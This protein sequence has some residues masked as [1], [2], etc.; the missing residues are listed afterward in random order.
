M[1]V[2]QQM[3]GKH[4]RNEYAY[5]KGANSVTDR[6]RILLLLCSVTSQAGSLV[7]EISSQFPRQCVFVCLF[8]SCHQSLD[9]SC[10][11]FACLP[12]NADSLILFVGFNQVLSETEMWRGGSWAVFTFLLLLFDDSM[13]HLSCP[14]VSYSHALF[15][16]LRGQGVLECFV[17]STCKTRLCD[18][19]TYV[20]LRR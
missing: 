14:A 11:L 12:L 7:M 6:Y 9:R 3:A 15:C 19:A 17:A 2:R 20:F 4:C 1:G 10:L 5:E 18:P 16:D 8:V 13:H